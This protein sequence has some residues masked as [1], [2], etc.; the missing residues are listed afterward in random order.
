[1]K[2]KALT[3][4]LLL[5]LTTLVPSV[6]PTQPAMA[7]ELPQNQNI[8]L[9]S[10]FEKVVLDNL[11]SH[12]QFDMTNVHAIKEAFVNILGINANE[13]EKGINHSL[14]PNLF[15]N[16]LF[17]Q[18]LDMP[19]K[20]TNT[21]TG[22]TFDVSIAA[23]AP[24][25]A[26]QWG[27]ERKDLT[28]IFGLKNEENADAFRLC[29]FQDQ[30]NHIKDFTIFGLMYGAVQYAGIFAPDGA[31]SQKL[32]KDMVKSEQLFGSKEI[33]VPPVEARH[34]QLLNHM[35]QIII[36]EIVHNL[37]QMGHDNY[38]VEGSKI[39]AARDLARQNHQSGG[40]RETILSTN[41]WIEDTLNL[42][43]EELIQHLKN[44][45]APHTW[46]IDD[47]DVVYKN[48]IKT[49]R[50]GQA[51]NT[52]LPTFTMV[53]GMGVNYLHEVPLGKNAIVQLA[54]QYNYLEATS[55]EIAPV[56]RWLIDYTQGPQGSIEAVAAALHRLA[57]VMANTLPH[58]LVDVL[59]ENSEGYFSNGYLDI[60]AASDIPALAK[61]IETNIGKLRILPQ[62][63]LC[64]PSGSY[65]LQVLQASPAFKKYNM[66]IE[67][68]IQ[69]DICNMLVGGAYESIA[70]LAVIRSIQ[71]PG[72][73]V[74][75]HLTLVGQNAWNNPACVLNEAFKRV[76]KV[77]A[78]H[79][80]VHVYIH[81]F[82]Y[83]DQVKI[84]S[85]MSTIPELAHLETMNRDAFMSAVN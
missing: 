30:L 44:V 26:S 4:R 37:A 20:V 80:N 61:Y 12:W 68:S 39:A 2:T 63:V 22:E 72:E 3:A 19:V 16:D 49:H 53:K 70:K 50:V 40:G 46:T 31:I 83:G 64:E 24:L 8:D 82:C 15:K 9:K 43:E 33:K 10:Q 27:S 35:T 6:C 36:P 25:M 38:T 78:A 18:L 73:P 47:I 17:S 21:Q 66:P 77:V 41:S 54:S 52:P 7:M 51:I 14:I 67:N 1:M 84:E 42:S 65:Q 34:T 81:G 13:V 59:P 71:T 32:H 11:D 58:A 76:A 28:K 62:W 79:P 23:A 85:A 69:T 45:E 55:N 74:N 75:L 56:L 57:C 48:L 5:S 60:P 29:S